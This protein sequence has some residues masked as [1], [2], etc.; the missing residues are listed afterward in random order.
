MPLNVEYVSTLNAKGNNLI[1]NETAHSH[2]FVKLR[3]YSIL[4]RSFINVNILRINVFPI[5]K[6]TLNASKLLLHRQV[7]EL[8]SH[9]LTYCLL[10][11]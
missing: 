10:L 8:P 9:L 1:I 4:L 11:E 2:L 5:K 3:Y 6:F 7:N